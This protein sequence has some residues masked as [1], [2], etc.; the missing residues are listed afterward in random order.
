MAMIVCILVG[1]AICKDTIA[2]HG[3]TLEL[4]STDPEGSCFRFAVP[5]EDKK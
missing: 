2:M 5:K 3:G 1:L 4:V